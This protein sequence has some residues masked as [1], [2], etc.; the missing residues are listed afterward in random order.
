VLEFIP[1]SSVGLRP[2]SSVVVVAVRFLPPMYLPRSVLPSLRPHLYRCQRVKLAEKINRS[3]GA[4]IKPSLTDSF[5]SSQR[6]F[7]LEPRAIQQELRQSH[8]L[9]SYLHYLKS[10]RSPAHCP[11]Q[12]LHL[13]DEKFP[14][15]HL[16]YL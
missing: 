10:S 4:F 6:Q 2:D 1:R 7:A 9:Y 11:L 14:Y 3:F 12:L 13:P 5:C 15:L 16:P 8:L